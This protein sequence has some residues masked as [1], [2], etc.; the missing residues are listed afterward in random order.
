MIYQTLKNYFDNVVKI[1]N[2]ELTLSEKE[3]FRSF[4]E[5]NPQDRELSH[6][7]FCKFP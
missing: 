5:F 6:C 2:K 7:Y 1:G 4:A 3:N